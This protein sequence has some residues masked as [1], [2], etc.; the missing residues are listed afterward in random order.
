MSSEDFKSLIVTDPDLIDEGIDVSGLRTTTPTRQ[1][2]LSDVPEFSGIK[3]DPTQKDYVSDLY[4]VYSGQLPSTPAPAVTAPDINIPLPGGGGGG[5]GGQ[6]TATTTA[7][8]TAP[9][10]TPTSGGGITPDN[11]FIG[12]G[13]TLEDAGGTAPGGLYA[14]D[15]QGEGV[16][17]LADYP[18]N[19][20]YGTNPATGQPYQTPR[21]IA[22]QNA[23]L[24]QTFND[25][26]DPSFW[27]NAKN[28]F[29]QTGE[30]IGGFF[31]NLG[32]QG[33]DIGKLAG[34]TILNLVGK[35]AFGF[36]LVGT[37][38]S[39]IGGAL[40][41]RDPRQNAL[42]NLYPDRTSAGTISSGLMKGYNPVSGGLFGTEVTYGLQKAYDKRIEDTRNSLQKRY[43]DL[44][45]EDL[46]S[47]QS[48]NITDAIKAKTIS[49]T[50]SKTYGV[51]TVSNLVQNLADFQT[52][53]TKEKGRLDIFSGDIDERDQ[54]LE[55]ISLQQ[56]IDK[57]IQ[58]ADDDKGDDMLNMSFDAD[59]FDDDVTLTGTPPIGTIT[60][61]EDDFGFDTPT[62]I[63]TGI[64]L[65]PKELDKDFSTLGDDL[66]AE[67]DDILG[68]N[69]T[70]DS[71]LVAGSVNE[72]IKNNYQNQ[73]DT[74][75]SLKEKDADLGLPSGQYD[76]AIKELEDA[77]EKIKLEEIEG[78]T[79]GL[80]TMTDATT[81]DD[82]P[83][84]PGPV[85]TG[86]GNNPFGYTDPTST[87]DAEEEDEIYE[88]PAPLS[89]PTGTNR[90]GGDR[91]D[92]SPA[93]SAP[94]RPTS[95][96]PGE[97]GGPGYVAPAPAA[98][99]YQDPIMRQADNRRDDPPPAPAKTQ[100]Q[101][102]Q[103][104]GGGSCFIAG[105]KV[106]MADGTDKNI[107]DVVVGD[108]VKGQSG[109]N[110]VIALD[111][112]LLADRKLY[113]FNDNEHY[114][115]TSE[116]PFM[117][118]EGWKSIKPEKTKERDGV[119]LYDQ[120]K[121]ELKVGDK[122]VTENGLVEITDIKS[123]EMNNP[124]MPLYN[125]HVSNAIHI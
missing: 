101:L 90:P 71:T 121:G 57:G 108:M 113:S 37:A 4:A 58:A 67:L 29:I 15:Y 124:E 109:D 76:D 74:L 105:T 22:D 25:Q 114:F 9:A 89:P 34:T 32:D 38:L 82:D 81:G 75:N 68:N 62:G 61:L 40:P 16:G 11:T 31:A 5:G 12:G 49:E 17:N 78:Q 98:P 92:D 36:P 46:D 88:P 122:L 10:T 48:G 53:K 35:A 60:P 23:V 64:K 39:L 7:P 69:I 87:F 2:L 103:Q 93:P 1:E 84:D 115:F 56:K 19:T 55:D 107:E 6:T 91:R 42:D 116:H 54:M 72:N 94:K 52:M 13:A 47:I 59:R 111:P 123:K 50:M 18:V 102:Q 119:E 27:E 77:I 44:T 99:V 110:K 97:K 85:T 33:I 95:A 30:D 79:A 83:I 45:K 106:S 120:L 125:H 100:A 26:Q 8:I 96:P 20:G 3:F 24:G 63:D 80:I 70:G 118:E 65:G 117:T 104:T 86:S 14:T 43:P 73:L 28:K 41:P 112:T 66:S 21:T 51:P